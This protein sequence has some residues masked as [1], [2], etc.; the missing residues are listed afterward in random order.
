M[1][2]PTNKTLAVILGGGR[3]T[4]LYPLT[5]MR[6]KPAVPLGGK[7]RL[8]D[9]P[10]S[11]CL[12]SG[13]N[14]MYVLTQFEST[15]LHEHVNKTYQFDRFGGGFIEI[16]AAQQRFASSDWYQGTANAVRQNLHHFGHQWD[17]ILILS[18]DQLYHMDFQHMVAWHRKNKADITIACL[19]VTATDASSLGIIKVDKQGR[20]IQFFEKPAA[21]TLN[22]LETDQELFDHFDI[23][24]GNRPYLASMGIYIFNREVLYKELVEHEFVDF[25]K[26]MFPE[27]LDRYRMQAYLFDGYWEDIGTVK[28]FHEANLAMA[29]LPPT[30][31]FQTDR[32]LIYTRSRNLPGTICGD[33]ALKSSIVAE[34]SQVKGADLDSSILGIRSVVGKNVKLKRTLVMGC[35][36]YETDDEKEHNKKIGQP[37]VGIGDNVTIE[38]AIV[39]KNARIGNNVFIGNPSKISPQETSEYVVQDGVICILKGA[40]IPD[41]TKIGQG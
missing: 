32:G 8:I 35:D 23:E 7:Y 34:G 22:G 16:L 27:C 24:Q 10:I 13:L 6:A 14:K 33:L 9:V 31:S 21:D 17:E 1:M 30:F 12:N 28:S 5:K 4:R 38:D 19:P 39:D 20:I 18:G 29:E 41:G 11:N 2:E 36:F 26:N 40:V 37:N 25:G 15:S 3:G